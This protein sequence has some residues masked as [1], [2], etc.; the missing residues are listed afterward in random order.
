MRVTRFSLMRDR[1]A[2]SSQPLTE[3]SPTA[4]QGELHSPAPLD[5][6]A[7]K[8]LGSTPNG[9]RLERMQASPLWNGRAF[10][11]VHPVL[12]RLLRTDVQMPTVREFLFGGDD[13]GA[14]A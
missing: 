11:N 2:A 4:R 10:R 3:V 8:S 9:L 13:A 5:P 7:M 1:P 12:P 14:S 6:N